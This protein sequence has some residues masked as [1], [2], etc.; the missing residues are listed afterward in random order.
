MIHSKNWDSDPLVLLQKAVVPV[1]YCGLD[2][3]W[4]MAMGAE[5]GDPKIASLL[6]VF[7]KSYDALQT[8]GSGYLEPAGVY[9][10]GENKEVCEQAAKLVAQVQH[11][12][13]EFSH[14]QDRDPAL[15][16]AC[17][18]LIS[19]H[20]R[21]NV[22]AAIN[23]FRSTFISAAI[24]K[25]QIADAQSEIA[26]KRLSEVSRKIF[27]I[28]VNASVEAARAGE[29]GKGFSY[30]AGEIR[31]LSKSAQSSASTLLSLMDQGDR[32]N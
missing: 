25:S 15:L 4:R 10:E 9:L 2:A 30:I 17:H 20:M 26:L 32:P 5:V 8:K 12:L 28:S 21:P 13:S 27:F 29:V 3:L 7:P 18:A 11:Q 24:A 23:A 22:H 16:K 19:D 14:T 1:Q 6:S 31:D